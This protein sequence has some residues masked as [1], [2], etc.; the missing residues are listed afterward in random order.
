MGYRTDIEDLEEGEYY[1]VGHLSI[2]LG[3]WIISKEMVNLV[4]R[5]RVS[6]YSEANYHLLGVAE[7]LRN[8]AAFFTK[9]RFPMNCNMSGKRKDMGFQLFPMVIYDGATRLPMSDGGFNDVSLFITRFGPQEGLKPSSDI[10][11]D[12]SKLD[13]WLGEINQ[14]LVT[15]QKALDSIE[16]GSR[17][18][19]AIGS[20]GKFYWMEEAADRLRNCWISLESIAKIDFPDEWIKVHHILDSINSRLD[21]S[22]TRDQLKLFQEYRHKSVHEIPIPEEAY[23]V[24][25]TANVL[26]RLALKTV[27]A[28]LREYNIIW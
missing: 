23:L 2:D 3:N 27:E 21:T 15:A 12:L 25:K 20:M 14:G 16:S 8:Y 9:R 13:N 7:R 28:E 24:H 10:L 18:D 6:D 22:V 17:F 26:Y 1:V 11:Q 4:V 5:T 19:M